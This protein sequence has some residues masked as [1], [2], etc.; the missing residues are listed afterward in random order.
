[1]LSSPQAGMPRSVMKTG[2]AVAASMPRRLH[3][4]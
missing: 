3:N 1:M 4:K 2:P